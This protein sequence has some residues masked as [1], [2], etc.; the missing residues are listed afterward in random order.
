MRFRRGQP[1]R[2]AIIQLTALEGARADGGVVFGHHLFQLAGIEAGHAGELGDA[3]GAIGRED[4]GQVVHD[5]LAVGDGEGFLHGL[6][7]DQPAPDGIALRP[8]ILAF[9]IEAIDIAIDDNGIGHAVEAHREAAIFQRRAGVI[10][11]RVEL[12]GIAHLLHALAQQILQDGAL[13]IGRAADLEAV[14]RIA[15]VFPQPVAVGLEAAGRGDHGLEADAFGKAAIAD[16]GF[17]RV[18]FHHLDMP[19]LGIVQHLYAQLFGGAVHGVQQRLAAAEEEGI[20]ARERQRA[21]ERGLEGDAAFGEEPRRVLAGAD[22]HARQ[23]F[24]GLAAGDAQQVVPVFVFQVFPGQHTGRLLMQGAEVARVAGIPP[25]Q[26][27]RRVFQQQHGS[28]ELAGGDGGAER[29][30]AAAH[31]QHVPEAGDIGH[32][33]RAPGFGMGRRTPLRFCIPL[34]TV[35]SRGRGAIASADG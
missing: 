21:R 12:R 24:I 16:D 18:A 20:G 15:P 32:H 35:A 5:R 19:Y 6:L 26:A 34:D 8:D 27:L 3:V 2:P 7:G 10:G 13:G 23:P 4:A 1:F 25:T 17:R 28:A 33:G 14:G 11:H 29:G 30:I 9:V 22:A 31:H